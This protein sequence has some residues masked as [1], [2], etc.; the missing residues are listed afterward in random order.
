MEIAYEFE[1][2]IPEEI[3]DLINNDRQIAGFPKITSLSSVEEEIE[4]RRRCYLADIKSALD[5]LPSI[6][7]VRAVTTM[8]EN[9]TGRGNKEC[10]GIISDIVALFE[11]EAAPFFEK[12]EEN[13]QSLI[14]KIKIAAAGGQD[15]ALSS[16]V[17]Q[18]IRVGKNW[19]LL[20]QP[21]QI[22]AK[23]QGLKHKKSFDITGWIRE[24]SGYLY[25][26]YDQLELALQLT[27][28]LQ[29]VFAEVEEIVEML[30]RDVQILRQI[31]FEQE[32]VFHRNRMDKDKI[33]SVILHMLYETYNRD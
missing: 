24:L 29:E 13:I 17:R 11:K 1:K 30:D 25:N 23:A 33:Y 2:I 14:R 8:A 21:I 18:L 26:E 22:C 32:E 31:Q 6:E 7:L 4:E 10:P 19:D 20:A 12:E 15:F 16:M 3:C 5:N 27:I 9:T 28:M